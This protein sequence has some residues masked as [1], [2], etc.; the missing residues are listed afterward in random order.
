MVEK[1]SKSQVLERIQFENY[2]WRNNSIEEDYN[3]MQRRLYF[4]I[5]KPMVFDRTIN[6]AVVLMGPR[7]VGKT[8]MLHHTIQELIDD[9]VPAQKIIF[10]TVENPIYTNIALEE[11]FKYALEA[12]GNQNPK[13]CFVF[14]D[15]IQYLK[16]W[17]IHLKTLVDSYRGTK[18]V[19]SGSAAAALKFKSNESGAG[20]FTD[21]LL[22]PLTFYE[23]IHINNLQHLMVESNLLWK[24]KEQHFYDT[25]NSQLLNEHFVKYINFGGYPEIIFS[26][27]MQKNPGRYIKQDIVDKVLLRDLPSLY[28]IK[29]VQ[30]LNRLFT[31]IC[32]NTA[33][34]FE[35][36]ELS[37]T[38]GVKK[39]L[40]K[41][42]IE[43]LESA[44]LVKKIGRV[45]QSGKRFKRE[46]K[47]KM[48]LSNPS[49]YA[50]LFTPLAITNE[51]R[52]GDLVET[53]IY[54]QWMHR[55]WF[56]P[57]YAHWGKGEVDM[58]GIDEG[59]LQPIWALEIKWSNRYAEKPS[60]LKSLIDFCNSNKL[61]SALV[62]TIDVKAQKEFQGVTLQYVPCA[63]YAYNVG[64]NTLDK[65]K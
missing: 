28:G 13:D 22:P 3:A 46:V 33:H 25:V 11:L 36:A 19:V 60:E 47:F 40:I 52:M 8:V 42:Y 17:E 12:I 26:P 55:D 38:S 58:V 10:I 49:L 15:E 61:T 31:T 37:R 7:R 53:A 39:H 62:T 44:F 18:F 21:F 16:D 32:F 57:Y 30:E 20:R 45:D 5:F 27:Q 64:K 23:Y 63:T 59:T 50:A 56:N 48:Y 4:D 51:K 54:S 1:I 65:K 24:G 6:R 41:T 43:Y 34:E 14:F 29:D 35:Y 2:W 9:G